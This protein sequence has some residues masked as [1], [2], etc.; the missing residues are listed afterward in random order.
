MQPRSQTVRPGRPG[1]D[2]E[3]L[4]FYSCAGETA[5]FRSIKWA[6][7]LSGQFRRQDVLLFSSTANRRRAT[8]SRSA[9]EL[10][11]PSSP[12]CHFSRCLSVVLARDVDTRGTS[13]EYIPSL[14]S[15]LLRKLHP[16]AG[17]RQGSEK[18]PMGDTRRDC[19]VIDN[20]PAITHQRLS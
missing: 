18:D 14:P 1:K 17:T 2:E 9:E 16:A 10:E 19:V 15:M 11:E 8:P 3:R 7:K 13:S 20:A 5:I 4:N 6:L 12:P